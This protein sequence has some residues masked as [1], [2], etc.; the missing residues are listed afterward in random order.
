MAR[1]HGKGTYNSLDGNDLSGH[2][3]SS[4]YSRKADTHDTTVYGVDDHLY[5]GG[6][7]DGTVKLDGLYDTSASAG[8]R[9]VIQP[10]I[11]SSVTFVRR[12]EGTGT[13]KPQDSMTVVVM[14]YSESSPVADMVKWSA[15]LQISGAIT[16]TT[17]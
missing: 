17:Q 16:S 7:G 11:G 1:V 10:L 9:A 3:T 2:G 13:G 14:E 12:P 4:E 8:P 6:L 15:S 5:E